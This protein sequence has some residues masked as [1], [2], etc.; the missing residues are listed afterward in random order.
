ML[1]H[2]FKSRRS[3]HAQGLVISNVFSVL[4]LCC[5]VCKCSL[6]KLHM[7]SDLNVEHVNM[8]TW[9][10]VMAYDQ[11][12]WMASAYVRVQSASGLWWLAVQIPELL[13]P[14]YGTC[15]GPGVSG[16]GVG[17][18]NDCDHETYLFRP[19]WHQSTGPVV[20][21]AGPPDH[22]SVPK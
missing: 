13:L 6:T 9:L 5:G 22:H 14:I 8:L 11:G 16:V 3:A 17:V 10:T 7:K 18:A 15:W 21:G 1:R 4:P 19:S 2:I 12:A 20:D